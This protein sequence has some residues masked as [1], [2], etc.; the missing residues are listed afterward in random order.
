MKKI[1]LKLDKEKLP[2]L[3]LVGVWLCFC[4]YMMLQVTSLIRKANKAL[5]IYIRNNKNKRKKRCSRG[6]PE[7]CLP[8][9]EIL[10]Q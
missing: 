6:I 8:E 4:L 7:E 3:V 5:T 2:A 9:E 10:L 1:N